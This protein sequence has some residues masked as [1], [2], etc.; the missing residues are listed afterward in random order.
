MMN[1]KIVRI[2]SKIKKNIIINDSGSVIIEAAFIFSFISILCLGAL[3]YGFYLVWKGKTER[4]SHSLTSVLRERSFFYAGRE[5]ITQKDVDEAVKLLNI[6]FGN[7]VA[8]NACLVVETVNFR[9]GANKKIQS[10]S[11][12]YGGN[13]SCSLSPGKKLNS[14]PELSPY[15]VRSRW[16]PMYQ[17]TL[18]IPAPAGTLHHILNR[19]GMLPE[20]IV[21]SNIALPR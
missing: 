21:V 7:Q 13:K 1:S 16:M 15:S 12:L 4:V 20:K 5:N 14:L 6:M 19:I 8:K 9:E 11:K 3:D 18:S 2:L 10:Y 17:V